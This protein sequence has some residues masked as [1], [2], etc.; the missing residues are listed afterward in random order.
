MEA[1]VE[2]GVNSS[3]KRRSAC[4][5]DRTL[6]SVSPLGSSRLSRKHAVNVTSLYVCVSASECISLIPND[7]YQRY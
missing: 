6:H 7:D 5:A 4:S 2:V 3:V 1:I